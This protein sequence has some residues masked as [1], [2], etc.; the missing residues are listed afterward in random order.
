MTG[1]ERMQRIESL[2]P[3]QALDTVQYM[4]AW[5]DEQRAEPQEFTTV[6]QIELLN[7]VFQQA[8]HAPV[9]LSPS[10]KPDQQTGGEAARQVLAALAQSSDLALLA[11]LDRWLDEPPEAETKALLEVVVVPVVLTACIMALGTGVEFEK[12]EHGKTRVKLVRKPVAGSEL[13]N[14]LN[15]FYGAVKSLVG[16][17]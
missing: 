12:D 4:T 17:S 7:D 11:E 9:P 13:K 15:G 16:L 3:R 10:A 2:G 14:I 6:Q 1:S 5:L 8:G